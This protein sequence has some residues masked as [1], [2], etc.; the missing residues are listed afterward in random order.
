[1]AKRKG[2]SLL[3]L[4]KGCNPALSGS[5]LSAHIIAMGM[6]MRMGMV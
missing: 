5:Y 2:A 1:V 3:C 4:S 6:G